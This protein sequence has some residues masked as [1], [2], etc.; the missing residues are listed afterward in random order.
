MK[1]SDHQVRDIR[2]R[3]QN[4]EKQADLAKE[5]G[6]SKG[7][8]SRLVRGLIRKDAGG[9]VSEKYHSNRKFSD[10]EVQEI[11]DMYR[12][13]KGTQKDIA[14]KF[15]CSTG[16]I[17]SVV[18]GRERANAGGPMINNFSLTD[19]Q[20]RAI[21]EDYLRGGC[22]SLDLSTQY[23]VP[24]KHVIEVLEGL[25]PPPSEQEIA[26]KISSLEKQIEE[27]RSLV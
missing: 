18:N 5:V 6:C 1:L 11:R 20:I 12:S 23:E 3:H 22:T 26:R 4:G 8:M 13:G 16:Y 21:R 19:E 15:Q 9:P 17:S 10:E 7:H 14:K 27:L 24:H 2:L 25:T